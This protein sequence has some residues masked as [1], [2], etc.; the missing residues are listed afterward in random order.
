MRRTV[1]SGTVSRFLKARIIRA[2][3]SG[4]FFM[5]PSIADST[6]IRESLRINLRELV[7]FLLSICD[8]IFASVSRS[9][10]HF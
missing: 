5:R 4:V 2:R 6:E 1:N 7:S 9:N 3:S 8:R 10:N